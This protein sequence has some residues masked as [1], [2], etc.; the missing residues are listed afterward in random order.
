MQ[1]SSY[2]AVA[3]F[4][5]ALVAESLQ[6]M[7]YTNVESMDGGWKGWHDAGL[8]RRRLNFSSSAC[9]TSLS[10]DSTAH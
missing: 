3:D 10:A 5:P 4:A 2:T 1:S 6:K 7:G 9:S 8:L